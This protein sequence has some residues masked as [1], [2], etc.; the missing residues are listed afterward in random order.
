MCAGDDDCTSEKQAPKE[1]KQ[2]VAQNKWKFLS[3]PHLYSKG[4]LDFFC[5]WIAVL[6]L[7][8][9][10]QNEEQKKIVS[11]ISHVPRKMHRKCRLVR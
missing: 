3:M 11:L 8:H 5:D 1:G 10:A 7:Q 9:A 2:E 4:K 6:L